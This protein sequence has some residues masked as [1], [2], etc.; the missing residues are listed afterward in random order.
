MFFLV[1]ALII[2]MRS[3]KHQTIR[4]VIANF[5]AIPIA[6]LI[7]EVYLY[8]IQSS[9]PLTRSGSY[10]SDGYTR[11]DS[12]LGYAPL[13]GIERSLIVSSGPIPVYDVVYTI[14]ENGFRLTPTSNDKSHQC[15]LFFGGSFT[16]GEGLN[17]NETLPNYL[18]EAQNNN[19]RVINFGFHG[20]GPHQ[21][22]SAIENG[23]V[24]KVTAGCIGVN[25]IYSAIPDHIPRASGYSPW[26]RHGPKYEVHNGNLIR[27]GN[28]D[29]KIN[30]L[31]KVLLSKFNLSFFYKTFFDKRRNAATKSEV[32]KYFAIVEKSNSL[33]ASKFAETDFT[34]LFWDKNDLSSKI[35]KMNSDFI[36]QHLISSDLNFYSV[37][38]IVPKYSENSG[39][40]TVS[41]FDKHPNKYINKIIAEFIP[42]NLASI[43]IMKTNL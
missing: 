11:G 21:M 32:E 25:V 30:F 36:Y 35:D 38:D 16:F 24:D 31:N 41:P 34:F 27:K 39:L 43:D 33:L 42:I 1:I 18:G 20:Y 5:L 40:Y 10:T 4:I 26:D 23:I 3:T 7:A 28:F 15:V 17:D 22:L 37:S 8:E 29:D 9:V 2:F 19:F 13:S 12:K 6:L 14:S